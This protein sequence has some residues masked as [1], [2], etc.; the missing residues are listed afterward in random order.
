[1]FWDSKKSYLFI[2]YPIF[3][4]MIFVAL[5]SQIFYLEFQLNK[6]KHWYTFS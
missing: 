6:K 2:F 1:M 3:T 5:D 4:Y